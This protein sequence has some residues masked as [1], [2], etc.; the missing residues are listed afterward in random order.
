VISAEAVSASAK[1]AT[2]V[3]SRNWKLRAIEPARNKE[4]R[5]GVPVILL[6]CDM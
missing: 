3:A 5:F 6:R 1:R 4:A 2:E